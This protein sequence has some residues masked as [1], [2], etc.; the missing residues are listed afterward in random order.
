MN[1]MAHRKGY[2]GIEL[3]EFFQKSVTVGELDLPIFQATYNKKASFFADYQLKVI[4]EGILIG[5]AATWDYYEDYNH[6]R[7][8]QKE[9]EHQFIFNAKIISNNNHFYNRDP[10]GNP[11]I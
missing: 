10:P 8:L 3:T 6:F 9:D 1:I 7:H 11:I 4:R 2:N 5:A